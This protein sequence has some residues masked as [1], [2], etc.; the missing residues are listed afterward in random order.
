MASN[1]D[2]S[3]EYNKLYKLCNSDATIYEISAYIDSVGDINTIKASYNQSVWAM[4]KSHVWSKYTLSERQLN[5]VSLFLEKN[6]DLNSSNPSWLSINDDKLHTLVI[7]YMATHTL[8]IK[9]NFNVL[10][11]KLYG[12]LN[13]SLKNIAKLMSFSNTSVRKTT[14]RSN[15]TGP[16]DISIFYDTILALGKD[17]YYGDSKIDD[18]II[19]QLLIIDINPYMFFKH[20]KKASCLLFEEKFDEY[21]RKYDKKHANDIAETKDTF[22]ED[23]RDEYKAL[24]YRL[25]KVKKSMKDSSSDD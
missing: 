6:I 8:K 20:N 19:E 16:I 18:Q 2:N 17:D 25:D 15:L 10:I 13:L 24:Q 23:I 21:R 22:I 5:I 7:D 12:D 14:E 9:L 4:F 1:E 11:G 3:V